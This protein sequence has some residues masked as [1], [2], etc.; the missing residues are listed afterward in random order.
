MKTS[1]LKPILAIATFAL[2][3]L[4]VQAQNGSASTAAPATPPGAWEQWIQQTKQPI[5][6]LTWGGDL[7]L[8]NEYF[9]NA[10]TLS[11]GVVRHEQD[12][13]RYR[14]RVWASVAPL[15]D[16]AF[17]AR[18]AAEPR[19]FMDPAFCSTHGFRTGT[20]W[21]YGVVDNLNVKWGNAFN[22][23][24]T[25]TA[26]RQD[27]MLGDPLNWWLVADGTPFDGSWTMFLDSIRLN[28]DA[29]DLNTKFDLVY[30]YQNALPDE[31]IP[32][33]GKSSEN[34]APP[35]GSS[36]PAQKPYY[37]TEQDEQGVIL[38]ASN[39]SIK[40]T[41]VDGY[42]I[43]KR[44]HRVDT[45]ILP[46]GDDADIYTLGGK[47]TGTPAEHW[48]Y[49]AEGAYQFG[50]KKDPTVKTPV[51][52]SAV[53]R[54]IDAFGVNASLSYLFK[55][56]FS[57]QASLLFEYLSGDDPKTTGKDEMFDVLWGRWPRWSELYIYSFANET[58]GKIAQLN[59]II[60]MGGSWSL[61]PIKNTT[62]SAT[63]NALF[64][65][66]ATPTRT[67]NGSLFSQNDNF[68]GHFLQ[69][70]LKHQF[71][72]HISGHLWGEFL[73]EGDYYA[74][75]DLMTFLRAEVMFTF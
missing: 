61:T 26:G 51:V 55:D 42:F 74:H 23:P 16:L 41:Q 18:L 20:E 6:W 30:I 64:A 27:I 15:T 45:S 9:N 11:E 66:E 72:K 63:Y 57:D 13:F 37:L 33:I 1:A 70:V 65:P 54:D 47:I 69:T 43:Y 49:S 48:K 28:Y 68:R 12:Y 53:N 34:V 31:W 60:R 19:T 5:D 59:N 46:N 38:Y 67:V 75:Q 32:T 29:K 10:L 71:N 4:M 8:R 56:R 39:K 21:R 14:G 3:S 73:W 17:N 52:L 24:L 7:R 22:Q 58:G 44:D 36:P 40:D 62:F 35:V 2:T 50:Q 25:I